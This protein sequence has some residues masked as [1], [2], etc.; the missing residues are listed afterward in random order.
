MVRE[1]LKKGD[2]NSRDQIITKENE[3]KRTKTNAV[4]C[5]KALTD[6][7][8]IQGVKTVPSQ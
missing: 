7:G 4:Q 6:F 3:E 5:H 1:D 8:F 2:A